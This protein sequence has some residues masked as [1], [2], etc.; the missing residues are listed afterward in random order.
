[1][2]D[3]AF[4]REERSTQQFSK[5][6]YVEQRGKSRQHRDESVVEKKRARMQHKKGWRMQQNRFCSRK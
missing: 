4:D 1:L 6:N 3:T 2:I 5:Q